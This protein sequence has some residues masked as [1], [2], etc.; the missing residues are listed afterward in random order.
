MAVNL[1]SGTIA[2]IMTGKCTEKN[3]KLVLQLSFIER[4]LIP[5]EI[6]ISNKLQKGSIVQ[7]TQFRVIKGGDTMGAIGIKRHICVCDLNLLC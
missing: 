4:G 3:L 5:D 2:K 7:L 1:T 6:F